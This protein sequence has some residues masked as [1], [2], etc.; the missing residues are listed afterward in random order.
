TRAHVDLLRLP[1]GGGLFL[2]IAPRHHRL[3]QSSRP[4]GRVAARIPVGAVEDWSL[5]RL[6]APRWKGFQGWN[7]ALF[8]LVLA[9]GVL[10]QILEKRNAGWVIGLAALGVL[11]VGLQLAGVRRRRK[12]GRARD[13]RWVGKT[14]PS[15]SGALP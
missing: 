4:P 15:D 6:G 5:R 14:K 10:Y 9:H 13:A 3:V 1:G 2:P 11:V 8:G 7:Y 12:Q